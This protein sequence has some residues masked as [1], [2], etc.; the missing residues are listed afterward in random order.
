[1][2]DTISFKNCKHRKFQKLNIFNMLNSFI[3][4]IL[5]SG[6]KKKVRGTTDPPCKIKK[7]SNT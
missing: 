2:L 3:K 1:M 5:W 7:I 4:I 6:L